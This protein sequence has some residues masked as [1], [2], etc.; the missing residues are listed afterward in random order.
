MK[1]H[2]ARYNIPVFSGLFKAIFFKVKSLLHNIHNVVLNPHNTSIFT[3]YHVLLHSSSFC[4]NVIILKVIWILYCVH[5]GAS[6][7]ALVVKNPLANTRDVRDTG[8]ITGSGRCPGERHGTNSSILV[9]WIPWTEQSDGLQSIG[10]QTV[11]HYWSD[12]AKCMCLF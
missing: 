12:L 9:W 10:L 6:H 7:V 3:I 2:L 5:F 8:S 11:R 1:V 4:I